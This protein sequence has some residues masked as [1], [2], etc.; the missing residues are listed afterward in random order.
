MIHRISTPLIHSGSADS[1]IATKPTTTLPSLP[2]TTPAPRS[3]PVVQP[4]PPPAPSM[5]FPIVP[6]PA[7]VGE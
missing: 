3:L 7:P 4:V 1:K 6:P 5:Q 2:V